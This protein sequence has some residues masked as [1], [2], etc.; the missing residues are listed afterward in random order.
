[1]A[2]SVILFAIYLSND[3]IPRF[4]GILASQERFYLIFAIALMVL[5]YTFVFKALFVSTGNDQKNHGLIAFGLIIM[6]W[7]ASGCSRS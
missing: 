4:T 7:F 1:M 6:N 5:F 3:T 2:I